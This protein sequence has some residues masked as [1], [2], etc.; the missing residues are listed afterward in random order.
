MFLSVKDVMN[1]LGI[2]R[3]T[4][5]TMRC[6]GQFPEAVKLSKRR[7]GFRLSDFESWAATRA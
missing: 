5:Y 6:S 4:L 3:S 7:I 1:R 2:S